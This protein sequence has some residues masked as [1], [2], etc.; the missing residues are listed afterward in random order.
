[1]RTY[2]P[3]PRHPRNIWTIPMEVLLEDGKRRGLTYR[4]IAEK[5][6]N[7]CTPNAVRKAKQRF[8]L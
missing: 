5:L 1:M 2:K 3:E 8:K 7:R 4:Q 6:G